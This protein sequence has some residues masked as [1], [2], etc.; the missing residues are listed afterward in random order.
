HGVRLHSGDVLVSRGASP[1]SALI[2]RGHDLP[3][4]FSH[5]A[6]LH[7]DAERG[8]ARLIEAHIESGV[9]VSRLE[10]YLG[11]R[12]L[13]ILVLRPR[14]DLPEILADPLLPHHAATQALAEVRARHIPYDFAMDAR[15][16]R[17]QFCSELAAAAYERCGLRLWPG[18]SSISSP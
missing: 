18:L 17:A 15:D 3:G 10:D 5:I 8:E 7:V 16:H 6:L 1:T 12:K 2:A 4:N 13:R 11:D 14:A 9:V